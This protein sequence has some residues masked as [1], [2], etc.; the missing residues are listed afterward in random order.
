MRSIRQSNGYLSRVG[1][2]QCDEGMNTETF[3]SIGYGFS[4]SHTADGGFGYTQVL[5]T[6][7]FKQLSWL[8]YFWIF[9]CQKGLKVM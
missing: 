4:F 7:F 1:R 8:K 6:L 9:L 5:V 2:K 3:E